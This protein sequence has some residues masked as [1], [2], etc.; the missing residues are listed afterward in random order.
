V[1]R[2]RL[3]DYI[4]DVLERKTLRPPGT[5]V[6]VEP[7]VEGKGAVLF[8]CRERKLRSR[9][10]KSIR[11]RAEPEIFKMIRKAGMRQLNLAQLDRVNEVFRN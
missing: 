2:L 4:F 1:K 3:G 8:I 6:H 10:L 9:N 7:A 11:K 5:L